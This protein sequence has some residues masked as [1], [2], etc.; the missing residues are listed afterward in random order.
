LIS[1][2]A[3]AKAEALVADALAKGAKAL[4]GGARHPLGGNFYQPTVLSDV[5]RDARLL[6]EEIFGPVAALVPFE[7]EKEAVALA[8]ASEYGLASYVYTRDAGR[9][10]RMARAIEAGIVGVNEAVIST[11]EAPFGG[12]KQSGIGREGSRYGIEEF[13]EIKYVC[14]GG[15]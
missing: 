12:V 10:F 13:L 9:A 15:I 8:N 6:H 1:P 3:L 7:T 14:I 4:T 5:P 2:Q 11:A